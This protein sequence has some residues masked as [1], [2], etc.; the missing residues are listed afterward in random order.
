MNYTWL[1][2]R[3]I[4]FP[5]HSKAARQLPAQA[6]LDQFK[7]GIKREDKFTSIMIA[8]IKATFGVELTLD[9]FYGA[10]NAMNPTYAEFRKRLEEVLRTQ[11]MQHIVLVSYTNPIDM[12]HLIAELRTNGI[13]C[14]LDAV[15]GGLKRIDTI[16]LYTTYS[17]KNQKQTLLWV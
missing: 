1:N 9:S 7:R 8:K 17:K 3:G 10:W 2:Y 13:P 5:A 6:A 11:E 4:T 15:S 12:R 14:T 16:S